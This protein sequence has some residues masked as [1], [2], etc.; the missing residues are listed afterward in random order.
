MITTPHRLI[1]GTI[2]FWESSV[3]GNR[4]EGVVE[5]LENATAN[6]SYL[7]TGSMGLTTMLVYRYY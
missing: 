5:V 6:G 7:V 1:S 3:A 2:S 4:S